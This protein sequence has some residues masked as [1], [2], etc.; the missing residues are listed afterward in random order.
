MPGF[1]A[2]TPPDSPGSRHQHGPGRLVAVAPYAAPVLVFVL[3][4]TAWWL[5]GALSGTADSARAELTSSGPQRA[6]MDPLATN[7][8]S[9]QASASA[10]ATRS[11]AAASRS[12][13]RQTTSPSPTK[14]VSPSSATPSKSVA[15][16]PSQPAPKAPAPK[17]PAPKAPAPAAPA[18]T[19]GMSSSESAVVQL[20]NA[21]RAKA[22]CG[23]L[24]GDAELALAARNH[25]K[26]MAAKNYF[27]H[28]SLDGRDFVARIDAT[29]YQGSPGGENIAAGQR[30]P[31]D[32]MDSWMNSPGHRAN[33]LNCSFKAIGVGAASGGSYGIYWTQNFGR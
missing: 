1:S 27:D 11:A 31:A 6:G 16:R 26:D 3:C 17:A 10:S 28:Q 13:T 15:P 9:S 32:V 33:I 5:A 23:A 20:V 22:G 4:L 21:E 2:P 29:N 7:S 25:S 8:P 19:P 30:T 12:K 24:R 14:S 18:A